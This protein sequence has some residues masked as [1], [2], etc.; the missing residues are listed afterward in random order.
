MKNNAGLLK[1]TEMVM[2]R[3]FTNPAASVQ[4]LMILEYMLSSLRQLLL[5]HQIKPMDETGLFNLQVSELDQRY[6]RV[7]ISQPE[8]LLSSDHLTVVGFCGQKRPGA[9]SESVDMVD[10]ALVAELPQHP[11]LLSY[12]TLRL[13]CGNSSNLVVFA[14]PEGLG[15]WAKSMT[16]AQAVY[17]APSFYQSIRLHN[18]T[19]AGGIFSGQKIKLQRTK[20]FSYEAE[21][22][23]MAVRELQPTAI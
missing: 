11:N 19:L 8:Q 1:A 18:A 6:H 14:K 2:E 5:D 9:N 10:D 13:P 17:L 12:S 4:D 21:Q 15:H 20:Y 7:V 16:H 22:T 3:P 23:W